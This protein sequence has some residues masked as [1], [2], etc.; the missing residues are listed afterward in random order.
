MGW[1]RTPTLVAGCVVV[2]VAGLTYYGSA[3]VESEA[4]QVVSAAQMAAAVT[5]LTT[6]GMLQSSPLRALPLWP[7]AAHPVA[8]GDGWSQVRPR[9]E[10]QR[11][12]SA[13]YRHAA[14]RALLASAARRHGLDPGLLM[15]VAWWESGWDMGKVSDTGAV[16]ILQIEPTTARDLGPQLLGRPVD[17]RLLT[18]NIEMGAAVL[19]ADVK[20]AGGDVDVALAS[21]YEGSGNV[22]PSNLD[23]NAQAYIAGVRALQKEFD[24]GQDPST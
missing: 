24:A 20:D 2:G 12:V 15:A 13:A 6:R 10:L 23:P 1:V 16:G 11:G 21:Y 4:G 17:P 9:P 8:S 3:P 19:Q 5:T 7:P 22:D 18:D 14:I